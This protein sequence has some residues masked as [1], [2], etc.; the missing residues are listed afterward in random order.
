VL[1]THGIDE[2]V[3]EILCWREARIK[4]ILIPT[5]WHDKP[6]HAPVLRPGVAACAEPLVVR[7]PA[8]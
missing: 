5:M 1:V 8:G 2:A 3:R 7:T 4:G 6:S